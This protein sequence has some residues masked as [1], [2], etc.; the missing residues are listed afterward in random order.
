MWTTWQHWFA[1]DAVGMI[2][3][4]P[5]VIGLAEAL[6]NPPPRNEIIEGGAARVALA[7]MTGII[8]SLPPEQRETVIP[9]AVLF[10]ILLWI[11]ARCQPVFAAAAAFVVSLTIV[12]TITFGI[13]HFGDPALPIGDR[14]LGTQGAILVFALCAYVL[15]ALFAERRQHEAVLAESEAR[16]Q[17]ALTAGAVTV[18]QW[19]SLNGLPRRSEDAPHILGFCAQHSFAASSFF[20]SR[21]LD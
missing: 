17:E 18:L 9:V 15:A 16:V 10:P 19:V 12:W 3:V 2:T 4:A 6:R 5:L 1:S 11:T 21:H 8:V 13:G 14:I 20:A 7:V